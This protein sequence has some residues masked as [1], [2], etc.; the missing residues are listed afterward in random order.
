ML[1]PHG[2]ASI[3][4]SKPSSCA[5]SRSRLPAGSASPECYLSSKELWIAAEKG[6]TRFLMDK[7]LQISKHIIVLTTFIFPKELG[8]AKIMKPISECQPLL[9][10]P[11]S[12][13]KQLY[14]PGSQLKSTHLVCPG[15]HIQ[16]APHTHPVPSDIP[17]TLI[18]T[19]HAF[20]FFSCLWK[21][22][23]IASASYHAGML[24]ELMKQCF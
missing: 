11:R 8:I 2:E 6:L 5:A 13:F 4:P 3:H 20:H 10:T 22:G 12:W 18:D 16:F 9:N 14:Q 23:I 17:V 19:G 7:S 21:K 1:V 15:I 24:S